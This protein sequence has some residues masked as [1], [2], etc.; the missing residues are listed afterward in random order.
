M[1]YFFN[2]GEVDLS[3]VDL[4]ITEERSKFV[5]FSTPIFN[6]KWTILMLRKTIDQSKVNMSAFTQVTHKNINYFVNFHSMK[7]RMTTCKLMFISCN[8]V[9]Y[10]NY[11]IVMLFIFNMQ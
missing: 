10:K 9:L 1:I 8:V 7:E 3:T 11:F 6:T 2:R 5:R 4:S